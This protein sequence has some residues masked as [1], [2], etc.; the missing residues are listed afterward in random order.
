[1]SYKRNY[2]YPQAH[3]EEVET[4]IK[5]MIKLGIIQ[6]SK[7]PYCSPIWIVPKKSDASGK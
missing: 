5:E 6:K 7:S 3:D 4:Q 1:M 2:K